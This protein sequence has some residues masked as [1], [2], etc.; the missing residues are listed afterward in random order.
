MG[1][2]FD[3][4]KVLLDAGLSLFLLH[5]GFGRMDGVAVCVIVVIVSVI[6]IFCLGGRLGEVVVQVLVARAE[7]FLADISNSR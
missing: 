7:W 5:Y 2:V 1:V 4:S 3:R 6:L